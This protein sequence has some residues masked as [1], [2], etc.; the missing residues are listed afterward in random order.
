MCATSV[1]L[2][3]SVTPPSPASLADAA[4]AGAAGT[5][6]PSAPHVMPGSQSLKRTH[7]PADPQCAAANAVA[8]EAMIPMA[9]LEIDMNARLQ[10]PL[11]KHGSI[12]EIAPEEEDVHLRS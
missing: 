3:S 7:V 12:G 11:P 9:R 2:A 4:T 6:S 8:S 1:V 5:H 10:E